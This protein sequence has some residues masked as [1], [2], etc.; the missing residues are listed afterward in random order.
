MGRVVNDVSRGDV[1]QGLSWVYQV[2][3][4]MRVTKNT[5]YWSHLIT[6]LVYSW[7]I[8]EEGEVF[9]TQIP[10]RHTHYNKIEP[11]PTPCQ[12]LLVRRLTEVEDS[13]ST[14]VP[15]EMKRELKIT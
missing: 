5:L 6:F 14:R 10:L 9:G 3:R 2:G 1:K 11:P 12:I 7:S 13:Q 4:T 8:K 15:Q